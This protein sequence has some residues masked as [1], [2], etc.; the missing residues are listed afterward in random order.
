MIRLVQLQRGPGRGVAIVEEP[1]LRLLTGAESVYRLVERAL[2]EG[3]S[4]TAMV[5]QDTAGER[6]DYDAVYAGRSP[7]R[8]LVPVDHPGECARCLVS[9]TGL[10]HLGS[11]RN[12]HEMPYLPCR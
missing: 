6:L 3:T 8:L 12:R 4:F 1:G 11:A 10:T 9:G 2:A 7:W 5:R